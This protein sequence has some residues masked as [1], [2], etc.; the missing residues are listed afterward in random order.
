MLPSRAVLD[1]LADLTANACNASGGTQFGIGA[2][3]AQVAVY[4]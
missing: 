4:A 3:P 1:A 2:V